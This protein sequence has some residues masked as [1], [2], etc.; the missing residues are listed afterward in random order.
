M[1]T[2]L[3][4]AHTRTPRIL[5]MDSLEHTSLQFGNELLRYSQ[6]PTENL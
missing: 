4:L 2:M 5:F 1:K 6:L 3:V